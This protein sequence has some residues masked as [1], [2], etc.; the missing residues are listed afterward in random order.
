M[1]FENYLSLKNTPT[2]L[3]KIACNAEHNKYNNIEFLLTLLLFSQPLKQVGNPFLWSNLIEF[4]NKKIYI[5]C[6]NLHQRI[7][8]SFSIKSCLQEL[9]P[10]HWPFITDLGV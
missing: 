1:I 8:K 10:E 7:I 5:L 9:N 3:K 2:E 4:F 6:L